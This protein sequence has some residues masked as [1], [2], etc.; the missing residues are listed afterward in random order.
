MKIVLEKYNVYTDNVLKLIELSHNNWNLYN[1]KRTFYYGETTYDIMIKLEKD[2]L[3]ALQYI[4]MATFFDSPSDTI[5]V[6]KYAKQYVA[7]RL[8][9]SIVLKMKEKIK[10]LRKNKPGISY[11]EEYNLIINYILSIYNN[12]PITIGDTLVGKKYCRNK[13]YWEHGKEFEILFMNYICNLPDEVNA[14]NVKVFSGLIVLNLKT[15]K[16]DGPVVAAFQTLKD[17]D[18]SVS[19]LSESIAMNESKILRTLRTR[20]FPENIKEWELRISDLLSIVAIVGFNVLKVIV[21]C[22]SP[23]G[24]VIAVTVTVVPQL[25]FI[26]RLLFKGIKNIVSPLVKTVF[27]GVAVITTFFASLT[28]IALRSILCIFASIP[29][30]FNKVE[31]PSTEPLIFKPF[32]DQ[33]VKMKILKD[34]P[35]N[36]DGFSKT[37][38]EFKNMSSEESIAFFTKCGINLSQINELCDS[39]IMNILNPWDLI[40][41]CRKINTF[42]YES[43][44]D[45]ISSGLLMNINKRLEKAINILPSNGENQYMQIFLKMNKYLFIR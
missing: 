16:G 43:N 21:A 45:N 33:A 35:E 14:K 2:K 3:L 5:T 38:I 19:V 32:F 7:Q 22:T 4:S 11:E 36:L 25:L 18:V 44:D 10:E 8:I 9:A 37:A 29:Y 28:E 12:L 39:Y 40:L 27:K 31:M 13:T 23:I 34:T 6:G 24:L 20:S 17:G 30:M 42:I 1:D 41:K 15:N 26:P